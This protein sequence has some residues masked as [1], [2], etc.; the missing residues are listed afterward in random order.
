MHAKASESAGSPETNPKVSQVSL[1]AGG[2]VQ[3]FATVKGSPVA[4]QG[5]KPLQASLP[6]NP[7]SSA[8]GEHLRELQV[9][10]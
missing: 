10:F 3:I 4:G 1:H 2:P 5:S 8:Q 6:P 9:V 7:F